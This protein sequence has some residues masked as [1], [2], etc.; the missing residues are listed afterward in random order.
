MVDYIKSSFLLMVI[1]LK[2][3][4]GLKNKV[5]ILDY[6]IRNILHRFF[7]RI[8]IPKEIFVEMK[9]LK[10][11]FA[12]EQ[13][14]LSP[15]L[16]VY[17]HR[18]YERDNRFIPRSSDIVFDV[19]GHI[20]FFTILQARR[21]HPGKVFVFEPNPDAFYRLLKNI[22]INGLKNIYSFNKAVTFHKGMVILRL[23]RRSSEA[24]TIMAR[25]TANDY[26]KEMKI[27]TM[28]LDQAIKDYQI[29]KIHL[30]KIDV[31]GAELEVLKSGS[32]KALSLT[33]K[34]VIE[35]HSPHLESEVEKF[36]GN[37]GFKVSLKIPS[38]KN[39]LGVNTTIYL[40]KA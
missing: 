40:E 21:V 23:A 5:I 31:E 15:Y 12:A 38:G 33:E 11:W 39:A 7:K 6:L 25:G 28:S 30:M 3:A 16:E 32:Q 20:G 24:T 37:L 18:I 10:F 27:E 9:D 13:S 1:L 19:G 36:L 14:E 8:K 22:R 2:Q 4:R 29:P 26:D 35:V 34:I 17:Y